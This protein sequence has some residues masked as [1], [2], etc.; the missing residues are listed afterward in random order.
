MGCYG[1][2]IGRTLAAIIEQH[3]DEKGIVWPMSVA[4]YQVAIIPLNREDDAVWRAALDLHDGLQRSGVDVILDDRGESAGVKFN[5]ADLMGF[6]LHVVIGNSFLK[7]GSFEVSLR[8]DK[9]NKSL[10]PAQ[11]AITFILNLIKRSLEVM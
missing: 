4:P 11:E 5:D 8:A 1:I 10:V 6:P 2:G 7:T 3:H 9:A